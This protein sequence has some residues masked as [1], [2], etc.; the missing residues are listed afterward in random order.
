MSIDPRL[1]ERRKVV[2]EQNAQRNVSRLL[3]FLL[4]V[5]G[6]GGLVWIA[7]SPWLSVSQ[8]QATGIIASNGHSTLVDHRVVA[9]TPMIRIN[10]ASVERSL[11][12]DPW[13]SAASVALN[14]PDQVLVEVVERTPVAWANT[15]SGW[16]R[17]AI[18]GVALPSDPIP[19]ET[20][21]RIDFPT[22]SES[23]STTSAEMLG[24]LAFVDSL[25]EGL[26]HGT[27]VTIQDNELWAAVSGFQV[28]LGRAVEMR[29]KALSLAALLNE[30]MPD[31]SVLI[32]IAPTN[33]AIMTPDP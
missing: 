33:P 1:G 5:V 32:L 19:D 7:F 29:E 13:I 31:S 21:A 23:E 10:A 20:M 27:V 4:V 9:G 30:D 11:L 26:R 24:A 15:S 14:W 28:R 18:D 25:P 17:R 3:R 2:A 12:E 6:V 22:M 16:A 8:V